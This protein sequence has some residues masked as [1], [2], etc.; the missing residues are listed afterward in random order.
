MKEAGR[1]RGRGR[2]GSGTRVQQ[3]SR[4]QK[5]GRK[6]CPQG[7]R[8]PYIDEYQHSLEFSHEVTASSAIGSKRNFDAFSGSSN[9]LGGSADGSR[10]SLFSS[11]EEDLI[12][13]FSQRNNHDSWEEEW[14]PPELLAEKKGNDETHFIC[15]QCNASVPL[16][17][18]ET[19]L[20]KHVNP[21]NTST[22][23]AALLRKEQDSAYEDSILEEVK[24]RT[25]EEAAQQAKLA[26]EI[27]YEQTR[28]FKLQQAESIRE[29]AR[30]ELESEP[31]PSSGSNLSTV[32]KGENDSNSADGT[33][34]KIIS[35]RFTMPSKQRIVRRFG[36][37][38]IRQQIYYFLLL[39]P[40]LFQKTFS[41][42]GVRA[43]DVVEFN[44]SDFKETDP[45]ITESTA[46]IVV[47]AEE[48]TEEVSVDPNSSNN[49]SSNSINIA[50][51]AG[52]ANGSNI[53]SVSVNTNSSDSGSSV[54]R[55]SNR[56]PSA[57]RTDVIDLIDSAEKP[58][59]LSHKR[60]VSSPSQVVIDLT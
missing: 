7:L 16:H 55:A 36:M 29:L 58:P 33:E 50:K 31:M 60:V 47:V 35:I 18:L 12:G 30:T 42:R 40:E 34:D 20:S 27:E 22:S 11:I 57:V 3:Q 59:L 52:E 17:L 41:L 48:E 14:I 5:S 49:S 10:L 26:E 45:D 46:F 23:N 38:N 21:T 37:Q 43:E 56:S 9:R 2:G 51:N 39:Q 25:A 6:P 28:L 13:P 8:C 44:Q 1:G 19:H 24:R 15:T 53:E 4:T 32:K 54:N